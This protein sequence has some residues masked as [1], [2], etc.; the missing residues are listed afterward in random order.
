[1]VSSETLSSRRHASFS[2]IVDGENDRTVLSLVVNWLVETLHVCKQP[3]IRRFVRRIAIGGFVKRSVRF[4]ELFIHGTNA[5]HNLGSSD[6]VV[7]LRGHEH[8]RLAHFLGASSSHLHCLVT[9]NDQIDPRF[10]HD[11][12]RRHFGFF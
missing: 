6:Y 9:G 3:T 4:K 2:R 10:L 12:Y 7:R 8:D 5:V 1:M 11:E